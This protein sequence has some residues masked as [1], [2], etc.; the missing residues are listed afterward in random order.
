VV[1]DEGAWIA[2]VPIV[3]V[4]PRPDQQW[5]L[6]AALASPAVSAWLLQRSA[7]TA[8]TP[9]A[10]KVTAALLREVPLPSGADAWC[11][12]TDAFR[13]GDL[14]GFASAMSEAYG[15]DE[16][17]AQWWMERARTVWSPAGARR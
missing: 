10:L 16:A 14:D 12:G 3:V 4:L 6:A 2:G 13:A 1:D 15:T 17:V 8:L 5:A 11:V 7:G 9:T